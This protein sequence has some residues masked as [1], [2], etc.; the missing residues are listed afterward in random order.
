VCALEVWCEAFNGLQKDFHY[1]DTLEING[2][3]NRASGWDKL[4]KPLRFGYCGVQRGF[5]RNIEA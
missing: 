3:I 5:T 1:A 2:I 4:K